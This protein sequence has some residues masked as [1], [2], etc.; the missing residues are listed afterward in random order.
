[1]RETETENQTPTFSIPEVRSA[2][3]I[4]G[5]SVILSVQ[6]LPL[7]PQRYFGFR[8]A[9]R[10]SA[11]SPCQLRLQPPHPPA[12]T[13]KATK[14]LNQKS[15]NQLGSVTLHIPP[16]HQVHQKTAF[17]TKIQPLHRD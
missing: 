16:C 12:G 6:I 3:L 15:S 10:V 1:M 17:E 7:P 4:I 2:F 5:P 8:A 9:F 14:L 11:Q 13:G